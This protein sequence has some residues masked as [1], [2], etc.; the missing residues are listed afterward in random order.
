[1]TAKKRKPSKRTSASSSKRTSA[2][3]ATTIAGVVREVATSTDVQDVYVRLPIDPQTL[4]AVK[5]RVG[6]FFELVE[7]AK[8]AL[9]IASGIQTDVATIGDA[10]AK[11]KKRG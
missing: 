11:R 2:A 7:L 3:I 6:A 8:R 10:L 1:M 9:E 4:G 5:A